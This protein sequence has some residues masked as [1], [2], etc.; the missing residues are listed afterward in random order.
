MK[1]IISVL[2]T[3]LLTTGSIIAVS[4]CKNKCGSTTC[5]N[6]GTCNENMCV[7]PTGYTGNSC[8]T[9][10]DAVTIGTYDCTKADCVPANPGIPSPWKSSVTAVAGN[11]Y[12][13]NISNFDNANITVQAVVDSANNISITPVAGTFGIAGSGKYVNGVITLEYTTSSAVGSGYRCNMRMVKE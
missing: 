3:V 2:V 4:S 6:G 10:A 11:G 7:C 13:V 8:E 9:A 1:S 12:Q 5:Q